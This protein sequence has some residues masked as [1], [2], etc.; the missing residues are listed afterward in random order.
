[1]S[2]VTISTMLFVASLM[3]SLN[4]GFELFAWHVHIPLFGA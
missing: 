2:A 1:M 3:T 4:A